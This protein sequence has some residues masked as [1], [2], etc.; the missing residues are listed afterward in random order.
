MVI[1]VVRAALSTFGD[2]LLLV[3]AAGDAW[4]AQGQEGMLHTLYIA[5]AECGFFPVEELKTYYQNESRL[6]GHVSHL[7]PGVEVSTGSLGHG[8]GMAVGMA[9]AAKQDGKTH[10]VFAVRAEFA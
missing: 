3:V 10:R 9:A 2:S 5:L 7:V 4:F 8:I 6:S 1:R